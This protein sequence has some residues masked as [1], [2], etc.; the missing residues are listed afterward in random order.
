LG[1][2]KGEGKAN[3]R[4]PKREKNTLGS[5]RYERETPTKRA[6]ISGKGRL[7]CGKAG[8]ALVRRGG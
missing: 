8:E 3:I 1:R 2:E 6:N 4:D 7:L 5:W